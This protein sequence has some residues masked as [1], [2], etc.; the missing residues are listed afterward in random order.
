VCVY[1]AYCSV[2]TCTVGQGR[3][4]RCDKL[5][6]NMVKRAVVELGR[7]AAPSIRR[8]LQPVWGRNFDSSVYYRPVSYA[9]RVRCSLVC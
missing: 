8:S 9:A 6:T 2:G 5:V 3:S 4:P 7:E 1:I